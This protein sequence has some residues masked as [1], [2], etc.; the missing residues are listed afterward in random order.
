MFERFLTFLVKIVVFFIFITAIR[1]ADKF[2]KRFEFYRGTGGRIS[3]SVIQ[4]L[5]GI[6]II[7]GMGVVVYAMVTGEI[8]YSVGKMVLFIFFILYSLFV[9]LSMIISAIDRVKNR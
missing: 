4:F 3:V 6:L 9:G 7:L 8:R 2:L 5:L 1:Y